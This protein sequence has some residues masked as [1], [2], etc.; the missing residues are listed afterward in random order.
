MKIGKRVVLSI[1]VL[2]VLGGCVFFFSSKGF[3]L[4]KQK[5][6]T[7]SSA[8]ERKVSV[9]VQP[10]KATEKA[11]V[12]A[13][14]AT[15]KPSEEGIVSAKVG[16]K[17]SKIL[18]E[19]GKSVSAGEDL[20]ILDAQD[21]QNQL[22]SAESQK[23]AIGASLQKLA[24]N[25]EASQLNNN[26]LKE[27]YDQGGTSKA[28]FEAA[29]SSLKM[30]KADVEA[31]KA[32]H[33]AAQ[34]NID[35]ISNS[36]SNMVIKAPMNGVIDEKNVNIGQLVSPGAVL[37]KVKVISPLDAVIQVEQDSIRSVKVGQKALV[38]LTES[39]QSVYEGV[40]K[41]IDLSA[42]PNARSFQCKVR[43]ENKDGRLKPG[44]FVKVE[45]SADR[46]SEVVLIPLEAL[47]GKEGSYSVFVDENGKAIRKKVDIGEVLK[48]TVEIKTGLRKDEKVICTNVNSLQ[49]GD[50]ISSVTE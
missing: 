41:S 15:L 40:V 5:E 2:I 18:F 49:D 44:I 30:A 27:L 31:V 33:E 19:N 28:N 14:K 8:P 11:S 29:D 4:E 17:V 3:S 47:S 43:I 7:T 20:I 25:L 24:A 50:A 10:V 21:I 12:L 48:D 42:D 38:K 1:I 22:R 35:N 36:L 45:V 39:D 23:K 16:G 9:K 6:K 26:R 37:G 13:F 34:V 32:N 46:K